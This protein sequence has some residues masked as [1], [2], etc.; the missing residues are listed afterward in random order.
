MPLNPAALGL[1]HWR[2]RAPNLPDDVLRLL[3]LVIVHWSQIEFDL[4]QTL[5]VAAGVPYPMA[6]LTFRDPRATD[7]LLLIRQALELRGIKPPQT[8]RLMEKLE[9]SQ[10][11]RNIL[12][13]SVWLNH[14]KT[15]Q[16]HI[17][18]GWGNWPKDRNSHLGMIGKTPRRVVHQAQ[19]FTAFDGYDVLKTVMVAGLLAVRLHHQVTRLVESLPKSHSR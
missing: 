14:P 12:A 5:G 18:I 7:R 17:R 10:R 16:L 9:I 11:D 13:H 2:S 19:T 15:G 1:R 3:G 4:Q 8:K 6:Q